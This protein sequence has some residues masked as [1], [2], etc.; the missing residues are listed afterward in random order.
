MTLT[1]GIPG[2][3]AGML[4]MSLLINIVL[5]LFWKS[6]EKLLIHNENFILY[7]AGDVAPGGR[8]GVDAYNA[9]FDEASAI[10]AQREENRHAQ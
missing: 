1:A 2:I 6:T 3:V 10:G 8:L 4:C 9:L 5:F 7:L